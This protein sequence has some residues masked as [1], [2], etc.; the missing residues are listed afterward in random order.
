MAQEQ[1]ATTVSVLVGISDSSRLEVIAGVAPAGWMHARLGAVSF[2]GTPENLL[3]FA[4][5]FAAE[6]E[7]AVPVD[8]R[9]ADWDTTEEAVQT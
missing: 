5:S 4:R 1:E 7:R 9:L 8:L 3:A 6:V 2:T